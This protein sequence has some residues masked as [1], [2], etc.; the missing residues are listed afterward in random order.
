MTMDSEHTTVVAEL[1]AARQR[2][3]ALERELERAH[4][5]GGLG[6]LAPPW[7]AA[8]TGLVVALTGAGFFTGKAVA[9]K[10]TA[11]SPSVSSPAP[12]Q[13]ASALPSPASEPSPS[14]AGPEYLSA[15]QL[16]PAKDAIG[17]VTSGPVRIGTTDYPN[18]IRFTC[19]PFGFG[20]GS[21]TF[22]VAGYAFF[23]ATVGV[24]NDAT[25]GAGNTMT[26]T[27]FKDGS[28]QLATPLSIVVG[29]PQAVH[30]DL[31]GAAQLQIQCGSKSKQGLG[32]SMDGALGDAALVNS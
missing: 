11:Q 2:I 7:I 27:F 3:A 23:T 19:A 18:S 13:S 32:A 10:G 22:D 21:L 24:P 6:E 20:T 9:D 29:R 31:K 16:P 30:L 4:K 26:I 28:A 5:K 25:N 1:A 15:G 8:I 12:V 14:A 17:N